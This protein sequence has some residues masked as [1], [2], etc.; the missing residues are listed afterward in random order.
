M[1][2]FVGTRRVCKALFDEPHLSDRWELFSQLCT[3][4]GQSGVCGQFVSQTARTAAAGVFLNRAGTYSYMGQSRG[5]WGP[6]NSQ[7]DFPI[8][9]IPN[10]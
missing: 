4:T 2:R 10:L 5:S 7:I 1:S 3:A 9:L 6:G 8:V